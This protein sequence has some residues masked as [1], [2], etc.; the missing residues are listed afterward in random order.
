MLVTKL[1]CSDI[2]VASG[3]AQIGDDSKVVHIATELIERAQIR[4]RQI[5]EN[6]IDGMKLSADDAIVI[7]VGGGSIV[8]MGDLS[9]VREI[10]RPQ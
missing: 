1:R 4:I 5:L 10:I 9:G 8:S 7:L 2:V 6:A 3:H